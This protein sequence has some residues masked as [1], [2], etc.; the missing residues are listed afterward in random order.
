MHWLLWIVVI[1]MGIGTLVSLATGVYALTLRDKGVFRLEAT[2]ILFF[3]YIPFLWP[4]H[5]YRI[6]RDV[7]YRKFKI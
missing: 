5:V 1:Y 6:V 4:L 3:L 2:L 7:F